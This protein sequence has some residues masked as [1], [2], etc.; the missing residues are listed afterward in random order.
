MNPPEV[1]DIQ[2]VPVKPNLG[3]VAFV[4]AVFDRRYRVGHIA[5]HTRP[6]GGFRI[7]FPSK[8]LRTGIELPCFCPLDRET[9][10]II[11]E[12]IISRFEALA[13]KAQRK[14][15]TATLQR[16]EDVHVHNPAVS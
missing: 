13:L 14:D 16:G 11:E 9:G 7:T 5:I 4:T 8:V 3:V 2:I 10:R 1:S 15:V 6:T 12:A